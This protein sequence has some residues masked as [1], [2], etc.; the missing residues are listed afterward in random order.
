MDVA[1]LANRLTLKT[2]KAPDRI[3]SI[4][5]PPSAEENYTICQAEIVARGP[6]VKDDRLQPGLR[7]VTKRFGGVP[8]DRDRTLW[9]V[10]ENSILAILVT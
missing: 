8:H 4:W 2:P 9:T 6:K 1:P 5:I 10:F 7:V 3:G